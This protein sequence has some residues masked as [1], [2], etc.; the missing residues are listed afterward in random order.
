MVPGTSDEFHEQ[1]ITV[2]HIKCSLNFKTAWYTQERSWYQYTF[3][4]ATEVIQTLFSVVIHSYR[5][6][7]SAERSTL[8]CHT[9]LVT[10]DVQGVFLVLG[11]TILHLL[12]LLLFTDVTNVFHLC[13]SVAWLSLHLQC[14]LVRFL[15]ENLPILGSYHTI[16]CKVS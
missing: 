11:V 9:C 2:V 4:A 6:D 1:M 5:T 13:H 15:R 12:T 7:K 10:Y 16:I 14:H 3:K 8:Y